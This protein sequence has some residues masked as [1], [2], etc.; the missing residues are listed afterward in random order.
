MKLI[1]NLGMLL[2]SIWLILAGVRGLFNLGEIYHLNVLM[3]GIALVAGVLML[4]AVLSLWS[5]KTQA[6]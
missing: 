4:W 2:W 1:K 6:D 5:G 3:N